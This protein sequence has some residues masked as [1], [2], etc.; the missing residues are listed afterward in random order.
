MANTTA[1]HGSRKGNVHK[2]AGL[3][4]LA[5]MSVNDT[6]TITGRKLTMTAVRKL[7]RGR[8]GKL[9]TYRRS[10]RGQYVITRTK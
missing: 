1:T 5:A 6:K 9:F 7:C 8:Q 10:A 4:S 3:P 2:D